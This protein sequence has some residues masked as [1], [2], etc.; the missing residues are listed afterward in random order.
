M[1]GAVIE[2]DPAV[3]VTTTPLVCDC[4]CRFVCACVCVCVCVRTCCCSLHELVA[5]ARV[6][7]PLTC[8]CRRRIKG[9][10]DV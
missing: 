2:E 6:W 4:G 3:M 9:V 1:V 8:G 5:V 10:F 7:Q